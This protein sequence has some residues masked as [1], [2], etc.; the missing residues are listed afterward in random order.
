MC[1]ISN[2]LTAIREV[3]SIKEAIIITIQKAAQCLINGHTTII[4]KE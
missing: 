1:S 4:G 3:K 2:K